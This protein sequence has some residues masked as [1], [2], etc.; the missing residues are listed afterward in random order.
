MQNAVGGAAAGASSFSHLAHSSSDNWRRHYCCC[1]FSPEMLD[2][3]LSPY[4]RHQPVQVLKAVGHA[5]EQSQG[6][7]MDALTALE[8]KHPLGFDYRD[9]SM[10]V[11]VF[12]GRS[13][14]MVRLRLTPRL[15][16]HLYRSLGRA[17]ALV[18]QQQGDR[19]PYWTAHEQ[20]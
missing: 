14:H 3:V 7:V 18:G 1:F 9:V 4:A 10:P 13:D 19:V 16:D 6:V 2:C 5:H 17:R 15:R 8:K 12:H 11:H 20:L